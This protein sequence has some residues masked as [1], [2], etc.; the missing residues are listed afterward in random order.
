MRTKG[1]LGVPPRL[2]LPSANAFRVIRHG[3]KPECIGPVAASGFRVTR[4]ASPRSGKNRASLA[5]PDSRSDIKGIQSPESPSP[6]PAVTVPR[7]PS[8]AAGL[9][10]SARSLTVI[11]F[12]IEKLSASLTE[13]VSRSP[14]L[15]SRLLLMRRTDQQHRFAAAS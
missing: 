13:A 5:L 6:G 11:M 12:I 3:A 2:R 7:L 8:R 10:V 15:Y 4:L 1:S 9:G 14:R